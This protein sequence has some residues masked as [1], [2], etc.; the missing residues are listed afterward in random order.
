MKLLDYFAEFLRDEV[1]LNQSRLDDLNDR[2]D[3]I[4]TV[5][6][7]AD[8]LA[9]RVLDTVPQGSWAHR[10]IIR[11]AL[12]KEFD[13]DFLVQLVDDS[14]WNANPQLYNTAVW[15]ALRDHGTYRL[16][17]TRK[18]RCVRVQYANF[19]HVD[20]V[21]YV[22]R[23]DGV[24][25]IINR[26]TNGFEATNP[27]GFTAWLQE[28]DDLTDGNLRKVIRL[29]KYL[30]DRR[31]AFA[32]KSVLLTTLLGNIVDSWR[33]IAPDYYA[34]VP[35]TLTH[36]LDDLDAWLQTRPSKPS[37]TDPSCP[38]TSFDHRWTDQQ[39]MAFREKVHV[40]APRV[41]GAFGTE[42]VGASVDAWRSIFGNAFPAKLSPP[43]S[44]TKSVHTKTDTGVRAPK[45]EFIEERFPVNLTHSVAIDC[46]VM[47]LNRVERR[48]LRSRAN[49]VPKARKLLFRIH[50]TDVPPPFHV[51][52][53]P[54]NY[55]SEAEGA[56][57]LRGE[58]IPDS[59]K[60]LRE[61]TTKYLGHH[62]MEC[63]IVKDG[64]CVAR[65][66]HQVIVS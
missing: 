16:M 43:A 26:S 59:G 28:K 25:V 8:N 45:E 38:T 42:V 39:Y 22:V 13:A 57:D 58:I 6:K 30:R 52:W 62:W 55:G 23:S 66:R 27:M 29:L 19:C 15:E 7:A 47:R 12:G 31:S 3:A 35:T 44:T 41:R 48:A 46:D 61:E 14:E 60:H 51:F 40:L 34:D 10:T 54:R 20:V 36:L 1:N 4:T 5:L 11:P 50:S 32:V 21:P 2:V 63:Y 49:R 65:T 33:T 24:E 18:D 17:T 37:I 56:R 64:I 53:K 9:G